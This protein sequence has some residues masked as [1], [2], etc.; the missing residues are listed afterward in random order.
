MLVAPGGYLLNQ[1]V[2]DRPGLVY[3]PVNVLA[4]FARRL[5][6]FPTSA[7]RGRAAVLCRQ[8]GRGERYLD[9]R[10]LRATF[11]ELLPGATVMH[12]L[13]WRYSVIW[14]RG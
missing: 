5:R 12:H 7:G 10:R 9:V 13:E 3:V 11:E 2:L 4:T 8:H 1:D 14:R 6:E